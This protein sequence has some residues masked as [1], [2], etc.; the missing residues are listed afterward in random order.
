MDET[1]RAE[2]EPLGLRSRFTP[3]SF[4]TS[5]VASTVGFMSLAMIVVILGT[6]LVLEYAAQRDIRQVL[7]DRSRTVVDTLE[8]NDPRALSS[9]D[10][11]PGMVVYLAGER[12]AGSL[13]STLQ[14]AADGLATSD[15]ARLV[16]TADDE[17]Q[18]LAT[19]FTT[20]DGTTGVL[21]ASEETGPYEL[22]ELYALLASVVLGVLVVAATGF[23]AWRVTAQALKPVTV[24]A[25]RAS[26]WSEHDLAHRFGLGP[27]T[28]E[29]AALG[30]T[31]DHLLDRVASAIRSEQ[32]LT[33]ELA[34]ELR[35]PLTGIQG[36]AD[37]A[38]LRGV[39][40]PT[41]RADLE[42]IAAS[43]REMG[44]VITTLLDLARDRTTS[45]RDGCR[46]ADLVPAIV[47]AAAGRAEVVDRTSGST[48]RVAA[49]AALV[50][51]ALSPVVDNAARHASGMIVVEATDHPDRV[52]L[53]VADDGPG[54][55]AAVRDTLFR[56]GVSGGGGAGLGLGIARR[57]AQSFGGDV[58]VDGSGGAG[59]R[60]R[61][62][63][64]RR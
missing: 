20:S 64:P 58:E 14:E 26:E 2:D 7:E 63:L 42:Q 8:E 41:V 44:A 30:E 45:G 4:R 52:E 17:N 34:H 6:H 28:N 9:D 50:V 31:L 11:Q 47:A 10:L 16:P 54:V 37:L 56:P 12:V 57:V 48:A 61:F 36:S 15:R 62:R 33:A 40:D 60:F 3:R 43:A 22:S 29:L 24:M 13:G 23:M 1:A 5:I 55:A 19:P 21:V 46:V 51:R 38:L 35:T 27:P 53:V 32:R 49:P 59:A 18:L 25:D 39:E